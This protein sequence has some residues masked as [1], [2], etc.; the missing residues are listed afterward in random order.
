MTGFDLKPPPLPSRRAARRAWL[1]LI[2]LLGTGTAV[3]VGWSAVQAVV[4][5]VVQEQPG[6]LSAQAV[7]QLGAS[8][9]TSANPGQQPE[10]P[11]PLSATPPTPSQPVSRTP[12]PGGLGGTTAT[13]APPA[14]TQSSRTFTLQGGTVDV[15]CQNNQI[16]LGWAT[17]NSGFQVQIDWHDNN[18]VL[19]V[20]FNSSSHESRLET[21]CVS[22]QVQSTVEEQSS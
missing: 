16:S 22:G 17:P 20:R 6:P 14:P 8:P 13:P 5:Q 2:W 19:E 1:P 15:S 9:T 21:W 18:T 11:S 12:A 7:H 4:G 3:F 10:T